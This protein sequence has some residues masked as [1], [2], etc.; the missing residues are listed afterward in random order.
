ML[1][2]HLGVTQHNTS[3]QLVELNCFCRSVATLPPIN[4]VTS[5]FFF[6]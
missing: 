1:K 2:G 6:R 3:D 5:I 4:L